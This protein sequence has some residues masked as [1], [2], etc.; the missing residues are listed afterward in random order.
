MPVPRLA[1]NGVPVCMLCPLA[2]VLRFPAL[3]GVSV[4]GTDEAL[5]GA[6]LGVTTGS[7][8]EGCF[9]LLSGYGFH[10][11][12]GCSFRNDCFVL[13]PEARAPKSQP[14]TQLAPAS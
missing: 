4:F 14:Q 3:R 1:M 9:C 10:L 12:L 7:E 6:L 2:G 13:E 11:G 5:I 8:G